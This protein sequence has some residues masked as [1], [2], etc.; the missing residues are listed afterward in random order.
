[1][2]CPSTGVYES[3][4]HSHYY[5]FLIQTVLHANI[6]TCTLCAHGQFSWAVQTLLCVLIMFFTKITIISTNNRF[7]NSKWD[8]H[9]TVRQCLEATI[10]QTKNQVSF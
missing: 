8:P 6:L 1:M 10:D 9:V 3:I 7:K 4:G 5:E 2:I